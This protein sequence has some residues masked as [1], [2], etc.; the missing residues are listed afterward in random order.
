[1]MLNLPK[2]H[3]GCCHK[4]IS[5]GQ[6]ILECDLCNIIIHGKCYKNSKFSNV[7]L[8]WLCESCA[9][10]HEPRY[11]PFKSAYSAMN[12]DSEAFY[13]EDPAD[14]I[15]LLQTMSELLDGCNS[16]SKCELDDL[17]DKIHESSDASLFSSYFLN[18]DGNS[19]NFDEFAID[20]NKTKQ[21]F[22]V[23]GLAETNTDSC[24]QGLYSL[25]NYR[26]FYQDKIPNKKKGTGVA[27]YVH[28][29][30]NAT[31]D[32]E[33]SII[34]GDIEAVFVTISNTKDPIVVGTIYRPPNGNLS[35]FINSLND[36]IDR[37]PKSPVYIMGDF[38][39][40]LLNLSSDLSREYEQLLVTSNI[41]PLVSIHTHEMPGCRKT[42]IDN[43]LS[44]N[45]ENVVVS[46][47]VKDSL[48]HHLPTFQISLIK[49][50]I[51]S[52]EAPKYTQHYNFSNSNINSFVDKLQESMCDLE[53]G[54]DNFSSF[55]TI[56][57]TTLDETCK[58]KIPRNSKR[59][60]ITNPW[61]TDGLVCAINNKHRLHNDW[62]KTVSKKCPRGDVEKHEIF[63]TYRKT[64]K[65]VIKHAKENFYSNKFA[66]CKGDRK[67]TWKIINQ[68]R[69]KSNRSIKPLFNIDN[70]KIT[71]RRIIANAFNKYFTSI[72]ENMN[73]A[74]YDG[75]E[76]VNI[77]NS[78]IPSFHDYMNTSMVSSIY[79]HDCDSDEVQK[80]INELE[81]GKASDIP[82][83]LIKRSN[84]V[85]SSILSVYFNILMSEGTFPDELK[86]GK[87]TPIYKK[88]VKEDLENYRPV[89]TLPI[90]G[91]IFEKIIYAR[92]YSFLVSKGILNE[93]QF[94]FRKAHSTSHALNF[95]INEIRKSLTKGEHV[96]GIFIDL[97]KAFDTIS[98]S[99]LLTKCGIRG[100]A[101]SL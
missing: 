91:K 99:K 17:I 83:K 54:V 94:G 4:S 44:N 2:E 3:C 58:L 40:D 57:S 14:Y 95:S 69:G 62:K 21:H 6:T 51:T 20:L 31:L 101:H 33:K 42:C 68:V 75:S 30:F 56:F 28:D 59:N 67:K 18:I 78:K 82:I 27:I 85:I 24:N 88:G 49:G 25:S 61:I 36:I 19:T 45:F 11:N 89:S 35:N 76:G 48:S 81:N 8:L 12:V 72:A 66:E 52:N 84:H 34:S 50:V 63:L 80:I 22:S 39:I 55:H 23:I 90:F 10:A 29:S 47:T 16:Y 43:I 93:N 71:D 77:T 100:S 38:N 9:I 13:D 74:S 7:D 46:G 41:M 15:D 92:L 98:H 86:V 97:S 65:K 32:E 1:M 60:N 26:S 73:A 64:L 96:I 87:I 5:I 79:L 53:P 70:K 37:L